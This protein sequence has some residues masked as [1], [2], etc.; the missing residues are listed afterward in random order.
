MS[1]NIQNDIQELFD[2]QMSQRV[3]R[4]TQLGLTERLQAL[5]QLAASIRDHQD[6]IVRALSQD[7]GKPEPEVLLTEILPVLQEIKHTYKHL[8]KW[9]QGTRVNDTLATLG[10]RGRIVP[11]ARGVCLII[12]PWNYPFNLAMGPLV[13]CL[14]AGNSAILKPSEHTPATSALIAQLVAKNFPKD[15]VAVVEG[16]ASVSQ[17][18]LSLP[19]DHIFFTGSP[20]VGKIVMNA[21]AKHLT[22]VT[23]E[24]GGKSPTIVGP[25]ADLQQAADWITFG[26]FTNAGQTCIAPDHVWVHASVKD[27][28]VDLLRQR[29]LKAYP[30]AG[31][32]PDLARI[33]NPNHAQRL[34]RLVSNALQQG[35]R[36][37]MGKPSSDQHMDPVLIEAITPEMDI[38]REE[39]FG[40]VLPILIYND[41]QEA[42]DRI[43]AH[44]KPLALY[45][46]E[47]N[48]TW[49][50][51]VVQSTSSGGVGIN[52]T[53]LHYSHPELPFGGVNHSGIGAAHG[54]HGFKAFS[55]ERAILENR[56]SSVPWLFPPYTASV[57]RLIGWVYRLLG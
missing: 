42:I 5:K 14:A 1:H 54:L 37:I 48:P 39:I 13:S 15:W 8:K 23:L 22:S 55:H 34:H 25:N 24:L 53:M 10:T 21:A 4:R 28:F 31:S 29:I 35:A 26:K 40:P 11:Q 36:I 19:F 3:H 20:A 47:S 12:S 16:D 33:V 9:M 49:V 51:R 32:S 17:Q 38:D 7:F 46:F 43:H 50:N 45:I 57:R 2:L 52:L 30:Q 56:Y 18:L 6:D 27:R 41:V 44:P